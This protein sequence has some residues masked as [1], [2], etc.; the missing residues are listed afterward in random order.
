[1][2]I[3]LLCRVQARRRVGPVGFLDGPNGQR[4][5][6]RGAGV[7]G[8]KG[9]L[10]TVGVNLQLAVAP[11]AATEVIAPPGR[12]RRTVDGAIK[13]ITPDED[14]RQD[15]RFQRLDDQTSPVSLRGVETGLSLN[16]AGERTKRME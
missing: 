10:D 12:V 3:E 7:P 13:L 16:T 6:V 9:I 5:P 15:A 8:D 14:G 4:F 2:Q 1:G 11:A